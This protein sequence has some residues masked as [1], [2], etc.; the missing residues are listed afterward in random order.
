MS[1]KHLIIIGG[2]ASG[3]FCA[4]NAARLHKNLSVTILEKTNQLLGKVK[5]SGGGRC[6]VT[7]SCFSIAEMVK[8]YPRGANFL[9]KSFSH[10]FITDTI[11]WFQSRGVQLK[12]EADGR[13]FPVTNNSQ[14][15]VNTLL[16][17]AN[18]YDVNVV[19]NASVTTLEKVGEGWAIR[20]YGDKIHHVDY[21]CIAFGGLNKQQ[22]IK[23]I[24]RLG[25]NIV[26]P[27]PSLF[28]F[29]SIKHPIAGLMGI[30]LPDVELRIAGTKLLQRGSVLITHWGLSGPAVL[31][32]SAY[33]ARALQQKNYS[34]T[35][36]INWLPGFNENSLLE[37]LP[38]YKTNLASQKI[39]N[40]NP[41][42]LPQRFWEFILLQAGAD[43][44][45]RWADISA[46]LLNKLAKLLCSFEFIA[47][48]KTTFKEEFVTAGGISLSEINPHTME[49]KICKRLYAVG[50]ALDIDGITGGFNFQNAWTTGWI[51]A[52]AISENTT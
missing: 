12:A 18:K 8:N 17:E 46:K 27:V 29:N 51:A 1:K 20:L 43:V 39:K 3:F 6:N 25:H 48:G 26:P 9:K 16:N 11:S 37:K 33:G 30:T 35:V 41:F 22:N 28:T 44:E 24:E 34:F 10:F 4:V 45:L 21:V 38:V 13:M 14:T 7:H 23:I 15:I 2:G 31:K 5:V 50:E 36:I 52:K 42:E 47:N 32:L 19:T 49:S 40:R